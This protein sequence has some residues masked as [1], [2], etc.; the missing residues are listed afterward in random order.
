MSVVVK[1]NLQCK[2]TIKKKWTKKGTNSV[3]SVTEKKKNLK[4]KKIRKE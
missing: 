2:K 1:M 3:G 4:I